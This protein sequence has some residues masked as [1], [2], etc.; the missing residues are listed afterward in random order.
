MSG[1]A[2]TIEL[3]TSSLQAGFERLLKTAKDL[4]PVMQEI[5][6]YMVDS[7]Q[8]RFRSN[9]SPSGVAW[10]QSERAK[11]ESGRTLLDRGH[12]RDSITY[13]ASNTRVD[14]GTNMVYAAIHQFGGKTRAHEIRPRRA[15]ALRFAMGGGDRFAKSVQHPGSNMPARPYLGW[16]AEDEME[17]ADIIEAHIMAAAP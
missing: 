1:V 3:D 7:T 17:V 2:V 4:T 12:L 16:S 10:D 15:K 9:V 6:T 11:A 5:G 8:D 13:D 14:V